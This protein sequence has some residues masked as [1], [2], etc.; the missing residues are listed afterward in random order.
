MGDDNTTG[1]FKVSDWEDAMNSVHA[2]LLANPK[3]EYDLWLD[4]HHAIDYMQTDYVNVSTY[5]DSDAGKDIYYYCSPRQSTGYYDLH[6]VI[7]PSG[8]GS[9][10]SSGHNLGGTYNPACNM[11]DCS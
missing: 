5:L 10:Y 11:G 4:N 8:W 2:E 1:S 3:C 7:D 9:S 6:Y